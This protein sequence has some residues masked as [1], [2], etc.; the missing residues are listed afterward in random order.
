MHHRTMELPRM[1]ETKYL[2]DGRRG[3]GAPTH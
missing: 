1:L 2:F 3:D